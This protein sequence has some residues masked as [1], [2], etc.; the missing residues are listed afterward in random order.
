MSDHH[1]RELDRRASTG[2]PEE[3][4]RYYKHLKRHFTPQ[5]QFCRRH[6][7]RLGK[8]TV[9]WLKNGTWCAI[10]CNVCKALTNLSPATPWDEENAP[11]TQYQDWEPWAV[12]HGRTV[13]PEAGRCPIHKPCAA[14]R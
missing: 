3:R 9:V 6:G 2:G 5:Q 10:P 14:R 11:T 7:H 8:W 1:L 12:I 13:L 4:R